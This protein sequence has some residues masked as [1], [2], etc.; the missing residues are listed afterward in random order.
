M[1]VGIWEGPQLL[2]LARA[3]AIVAMKNAVTCKSHV[4]FCMETVD[5]QELMSCNGHKHVGGA[6]VLFTS[7][8]AY[9]YNKQRSDL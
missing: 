3:L 7:L 8:R 6:A 2:P 1:A 5:L 4:V 9:Y